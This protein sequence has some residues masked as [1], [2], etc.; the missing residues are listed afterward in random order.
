MII[1]DIIDLTSRATNELRNVRRELW[2]Y[3]LL[4][5]TWEQ[6]KYLKNV[7]SFPVNDA[8]NINVLIKV[9]SF[10]AE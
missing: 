4:P 5:L 1:E 8:L 2:K 7:V 9:M 10:V 6:K 3:K